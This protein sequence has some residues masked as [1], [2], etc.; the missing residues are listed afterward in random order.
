MTQIERMALPLYLQGF[1]FI[2]EA[3][4]LHAKPQVPALE[5]KNVDLSK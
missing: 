2:P 5:S 1:L 4:W 3:G